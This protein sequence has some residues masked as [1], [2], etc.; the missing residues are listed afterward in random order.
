[1]NL[2]Q[3]SL[4]V[5]ILTLAVTSLA[6]LVDIIQLIRDHTIN[7]PTRNNRRTFSLV[8]IG[9]VFAVL[10]SALIIRFLVSIPPDA[11]AQIIQTETQPVTQV[12]ILDATE[13]YTPQV[14]EPIELTPTDA[15]IIPTNTVTVPPYTNTPNMSTQEHPSKWEIDGIGS[16][17]LV[18]DALEIHATSPTTAYTGEK[19]WHTYSV[20]VSFMV[21]DINNNSK[22]GVVIRKSNAC[23][24]YYIR[25]T[26]S[27]NNPYQVLAELLKYTNCDQNMF[28]LLDQK[29][30]NLDSVLLHN[31]SIMIGND[32][33]ADIRVWIDS[34]EILSF[35]DGENFIYSGGVGLRVEYATIRF[36]NLNVEINK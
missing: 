5:A 22:Y 2:N 24:L 15:L 4:F 18:G 35:S 31:I 1:M 8:T 13:T 30:V 33:S 19:Y 3:I 36:D 17:N 32:S 26:P 28:S 7:I 21:M 9:L 23:Q 11:S 29:V 25:L 27:N 16:V 6:L 10:I 14:V 20:S 34:Q 12:G